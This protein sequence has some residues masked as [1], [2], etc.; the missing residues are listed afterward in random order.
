LCHEH[1]LLQVSNYS[2]GVTPAFLIA[3]FGLR[4]EEIWIADW[5]IQKSEI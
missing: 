2:A 5:K 3:D 4:I 1:V